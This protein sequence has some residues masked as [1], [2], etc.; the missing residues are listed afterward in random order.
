[1]SIASTSQHPLAKDVFN[2]GRV[3]LE[4]QQKMLRE[5]AEALKKARVEA[6]ERGRLASQAWAAKKKGL[7]TGKILQ[8]EA[9]KENSKPDAEVG[10]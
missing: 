2:R 10:H 3:D 4:D 6:A 1:M 7:V 8:Q 9:G 5:K